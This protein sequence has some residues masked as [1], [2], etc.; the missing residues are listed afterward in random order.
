MLCSSHP[1]FHL[2][3]QV[4]NFSC[5]LFK[6]PVFV[7]T[8]S[9]HAPVHLLVEE[10][11]FPVN[12]TSHH[13]RAVFPVTCSSH[14]QSPVLPITYSSQRCCQIH[15]PVISVSSTV[16]LL[17][18]FPVN[19]SKSQCFQLPPMFLATS[20]VISVTSYL[21][22]SPMFSGACSS[23]VFPVKCPSAVFCSSHQCMLFPVPV[24]NVTS[25]VFQSQS[26]SSYVLKSPMSPV[27]SVIMFQSP[28]FLITCSSPSVCSYLF[29]SPVFPITLCSSHQCFLFWSPMFPVTVTSGY[30]SFIVRVPVPAFPV[31]F[32]KLL[33][34]AITV[35]VTSAVTCSSR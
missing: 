17:P 22:K 1:F 33:V 16:F 34:F 30:R 31:A 5:Y 15:I 10:K 9:S 12:C 2:H 28:V 23:P 13:M 3:V 26:V 14:L 25:Y 35:P 32:S 11:S 29:Q 24:T 6:S 19:M 18:V 7:G 20:I 8:C 4:N 27:L 21:L